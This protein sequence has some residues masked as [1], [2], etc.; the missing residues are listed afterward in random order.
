MIAS[1]L[2]LAPKPVDDTVGWYE[3][4]A[5][6]YAA[7]TLGRNPG[8]LREAFA[9]RLP[10]GGSILDAGSGSGRDTLAFI[11][12]G[13]DVDAFDA[14]EGLAVFSSRLTGRPTQVARFESYVGPHDRYDGVWAFASLLHVREA[15]IPPVV[16]RLA[17]CL[18]RGGWL[19]AN[20]KIGKGERL[21]EFGRRY[22][23]MTRPQLL[24]LFGAMPAWQCVEITTQK[25]EAAF[26]RPTGWINIFAQAA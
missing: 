15:D 13:F 24:R 1:A 12:A 23:D 17:A 20:F 26:G 19:F 4:S 9:A 3:R 11:E 6:A 14:S 18:K 10:P 8:F 21:D 16:G 2:K 25:A 5:A 7:E 22:T